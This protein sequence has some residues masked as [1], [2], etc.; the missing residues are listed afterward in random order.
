ML[1]H[2]LKGMQ[3]GRTWP[4]RRKLRLFACGCCRRIWHL[5]DDASREVVAAAEDFADRKIDKPAL[6]SAQ[7]MALR[8]RS[9]EHQELHLAH[10]S[11]AAYTTAFPTSVPM[12]M[13]EVARQAALAE[14]LGPAL[15]Y[16]ADLLREIFGN[17]FRNVVVLPGWLTWSGGAISKLARAICDERRFEDLPILADA[18]E[19]AG[20]TEEA[21]L[22]HC[23]EPGEH[24]RGCWVVDLILDKN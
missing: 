6:F 5:L 13:P 4:G 24:V 1:A 17:P 12:V 15:A 16:Q 8:S 7:M 9:R 23:R 14:Q 20:C 22:K 19:E 3:L 2:L 10:A 21:I 18:L 11:E